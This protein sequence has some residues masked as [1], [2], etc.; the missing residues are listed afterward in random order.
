[1]GPHRLGSYEEGHEKEQASPKALRYQA[2]NRILPGGRKHIM[3]DRPLHCPRCGGEPKTATHVL[4][5]KDQR[6]VLQW[7]TSIGKLTKWMVESKTDPIIT[8]AIITGIRR[9]RDDSGQYI[10]YRRGY[11]EAT[12]E[13]NEI[14]W[15][16]LL[17]GRLSKKWR[18]LQQSHYERIGSP[19]QAASWVSGLIV[20]LWQV[21]FDLWEHRNDI[22]H[23]SEASER[24]KGLEEIDKQIREQYQRGWASLP[25]RHQKHFQKDI[26]ELLT[27]GP[28]VR[29]QW[30][31]VAQE[32]RKRKQTTEEQ[33]EQVSQ[34]QRLCQFLNSG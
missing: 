23:N 2:Y 16:N 20:Q 19:R 10:H 33:S 26:Q 3:A 4:K 1:M 27:S 24:L 9:W 13:Q 17:R 25:T 5:C 11:K 22:L 8:N 6:A 34:R 28:E 18:A 32:Y 12:L 7:A 29:K 31:A 21:S 30:L 14:N 15:E